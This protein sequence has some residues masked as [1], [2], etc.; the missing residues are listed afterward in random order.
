MTSNIAF[1]CHVFT[2]VVRLCVDGP[3]L[4]CMHTRPCH[5]DLT[6]LTKLDFPEPTGPHIIIRAWRVHT[7]SSGVKSDISQTNFAF[8]LKN[9]NTNILCE[10]DISNEFL[11]VSA[12]TQLLLLENVEFINPL[13]CSLPAKHYLYGVHLYI[14]T[15]YFHY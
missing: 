7:D 3:D 13:K 6:E 11:S 8:T 10:R 1:Y 12:M 15:Y 5:T 4:T 2:F 14:F 9:L